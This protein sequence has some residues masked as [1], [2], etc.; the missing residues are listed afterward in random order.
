MELVKK[1]VLSVAKKKS[2]SAAAKALF[3]SQ[4]ALSLAIGRLE[5]ELAFRIFDRTT[6]PISL[7]KEGRVYLDYLYS[8][9]ALELEMKQRIKAI[10]ELSYGSIA[11]GASCHTSY[12]LLPDVIASFSQSFPKMDIRLDMGAGRDL[13][14]LYE[15]LDSGELDVILKYDFDPHRHKAVPLL[16]ERLAVAMPR[17]MLNE[18]LLP[19]AI[20]AKEFLSQSYPPEKELSDPALLGDI[21]FILLGEQS[22]TLSQLTADLAIQKSAPC[23]ISGVKHIQ[24]HYNMMEKGLGAVLISDFHLLT[25]ELLQRDIVFF[26]PA[27]PSSH[28][29][30]YALTKYGA[31]ENKVIN[32]FL[33]TALRVC[34]DYEKQKESI[35]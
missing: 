33:D 7:T 17:A 23:F 2:F 29:T 26:I 3:I 14:A 11:V 13:A 21:P 19:Y 5:S 28:R 30:L 1:Y 18:A 34:E 16:A 31:R 22:R 20:T 24:M 9:E 4:P 27:L 10:S 6:T 8:E 32:A 25:S 15:K 35:L 12:R